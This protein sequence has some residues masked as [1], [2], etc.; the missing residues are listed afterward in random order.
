MKRVNLASMQNRK[1]RNEQSIVQRKIQRS[2]EKNQVCYVCNVCLLQQQCSEGNLYDSLIP[3]HVALS[4]NNVV[5][6][7]AHVFTTT[8]C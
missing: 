6:P 5:P 7:P 1:S 8:R 2:M 3:L 4:C